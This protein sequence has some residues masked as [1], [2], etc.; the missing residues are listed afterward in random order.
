MHMAW[1][2]NIGGRLKS[3]FSY[4]IG[5]ID[6]TFPLPLSQNNYNAP[7]P[8]PTPSSPPAPTIP[9]Q[10]W[11]SSTPRPHVCDLHKAHQALDLAVDRLYRRRRFTSDRECV[12]HL[13]GLYEKMLVSLTA[14]AKPKGGKGGRGKRTPQ[15]ADN[16]DY[17]QKT[18]YDF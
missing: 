13:F 17:V 16:L 14:K 6:Y 15:D 18:L 12:E 11:P 9:T 10:R 5:I 1:V 2:R 3:D 7:R 8:L 4:G